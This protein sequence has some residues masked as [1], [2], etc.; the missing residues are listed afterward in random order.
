MHTVLTVKGKR[1]DLTI[2]TFPRKIKFDIVRS[3][4]SV[5]GGKKEKFCLFIALNLKY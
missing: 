1:M 2:H 5:W 4:V 3:E